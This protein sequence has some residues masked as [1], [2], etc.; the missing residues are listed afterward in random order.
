M[1][2]RKQTKQLYTNPNS[3]FEEYLV[4]SLSSKIPQSHKV[5]NLN[6]LATMLPPKKNNRNSGIR[7]STRGG[8]KKTVR[9]NNSVRRKKTTR[10]KKSTRKRR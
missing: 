2:T 9:R 7:H 6:E 10:R 5:M 4:N 1:S 3:R 8:R